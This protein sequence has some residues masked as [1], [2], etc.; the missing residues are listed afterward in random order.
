MSLFK[1]DVNSNKLPHDNGDCKK[2]IIDKTMNKCYFIEVVIQFV[3]SRV[4]TVEIE[5]RIRDLNNVGC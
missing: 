4:T 2:K 1:V 3:H 5:N